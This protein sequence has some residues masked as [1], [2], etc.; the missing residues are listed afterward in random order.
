MGEDV[1]SIAAHISN[2]TLNEYPEPLADGKKNVIV[3]S[4]GLTQYVIFE[5]FSSRT[6][7]SSLRS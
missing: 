6:S 1:D 3:L 2:R 5:F 7:S 4:T